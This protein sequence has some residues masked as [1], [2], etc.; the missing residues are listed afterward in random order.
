MIDWLLAFSALL[1]ALTVDRTI[2][3]A[4]QLWGMRRV[5]RS[6]VKNM[7]NALERW[8]AQAKAQG[9]SKQFN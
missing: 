7:D 5:G 1:A 4:V 6:I 8:D 9:K 2:G 3:S